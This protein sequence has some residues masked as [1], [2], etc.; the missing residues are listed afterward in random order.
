MNYLCVGK[1]FATLDEANSYSNYI[2]KH[3]RVVLGVFK[4]DRRVTHTFQLREV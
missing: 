2:M 4:T 1:V 3:T